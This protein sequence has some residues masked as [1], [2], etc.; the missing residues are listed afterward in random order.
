MWPGGVR[1]G[2]GPECVDGSMD[3]GWDRRMKG[4]NG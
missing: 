2:L 4:T 3:R 1:T